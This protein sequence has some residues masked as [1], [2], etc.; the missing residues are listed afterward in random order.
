MARAVAVSIQ[1]PLFEN[2]L[3]A[4]VAG[5]AFRAGADGCRLGGR[6]LEHAE[7]RRAAERARQELPRDVVDGDARAG[8][9]F[10]APAMRMAVD[11]KG[12]AIRVDRLLEPAGSEER[13]NLQRL[14]LDG[15]LD[16]RI[17]KQRDGRQR[18]DS[19]QRRLEL[20]RLVDGFADE[21]LDAVFPPRAESALAE[22]AAKPFH[23]G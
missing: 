14:A 23:A 10:R 17:V 13:V 1:R 15:A 18:L 21:V 7:R 12:D 5:A 22:A 11:D 9:A 16:G 19:R 4:P 20:E 6:H 3:P 2:Q 8:L